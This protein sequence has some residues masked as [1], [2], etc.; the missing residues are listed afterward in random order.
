MTLAFC[1]VEN[2]WI[3]TECGI[4][5]KELSTLTQRI[6]ALGETLNLFASF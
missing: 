4:K 2:W 3:V 6:N 5:E 1:K